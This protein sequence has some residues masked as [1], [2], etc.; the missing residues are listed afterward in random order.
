MRIDLEDE[1]LHPTLPPG[2]TFVTFVENQDEEAFF[3][4]IN[5]SFVDHWTSS[6]RSFE[7]W[8]KTAKS[9]QYDTGLWLQLFDG[10]RRA[11]VSQGKITSEYGWI[12]YLGVLPS[13][14]RRGLATAMLQEAFRRFW[15]EGIRVVELGVD[16]E[17]RQS[18][19]D[20][21]TNLGMRETHSYEAT[22]KVL[23]PGV[24]WREEETPLSG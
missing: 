19:V 1:P 11:G 3:A 4:V 15:D 12:H 23:R 13:Y 18:A 20:L 16:S 6:P 5:E 7:K 8:L 9:G 24:K 10:D 22:E 21:Y 17:N 2:F 14:R